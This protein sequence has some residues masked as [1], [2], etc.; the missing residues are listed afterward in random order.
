LLKALNWL[1]AWQ[2]ETTVK[3]VEQ[4]QRNGKDAFETRNNIQ[5]FAAQKL[6][7]IYG[8]RTI[9]YVFYKFV[10]S[11]PDSAEKQVLQQVLSFYGA[12]LVIKYSAVFYRGGYFRENSQ[13]LDLYEQ[14]ILGLLPLLK[15]EAIAL[16][17]AIA[18]SDFILNSPLG[19]SDGN[20]YQ[21]LQR[22]IV[23]TPGV[24]ERLHWWRDVTFKDYLKRAKL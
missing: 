20:V 11:L 24:Y 18:P 10:R 22:T 19:M 23:S 7:I 3:R 15:D 1:T 17:D 13:Q 9:Y 16:V 2:L 8:E 12:H 6:S 14:G 4:Q 21:H 5:V